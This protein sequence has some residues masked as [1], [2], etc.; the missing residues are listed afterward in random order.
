MTFNISHSNSNK[1]KR[2][3]VFFLWNSLFIK[4]LGEK[5]IPIIIDNEIE[6][7]NTIKLNTCKSAQQ[8]TKYFFFYSI[9]FIKT[10]KF[11]N[12]NIYQKKYSLNFIPFSLL[13]SGS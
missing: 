3:W 10:Q 2:S 9:K 12:I 4:F 6:L 13:F 7:S 1:G 8:E 11:I 5:Y